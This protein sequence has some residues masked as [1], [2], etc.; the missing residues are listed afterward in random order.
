MSFEQPDANLL[1]T[2]SQ[3]LLLQYD[4]CIPQFCY[5]VTVNV[6]LLLAL[7]PAVVTAIFPDFAPAGTVAVIVVP[8]FTV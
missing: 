8:E 5:G 1:T 2:L 6:P 3:F 4:F 7:P